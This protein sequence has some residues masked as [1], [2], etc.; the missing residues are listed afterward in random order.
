[1]VSAS[2]AYVIEIGG[3]LHDIG[4]IGVPDAILL[5]P[6]PLT[7][8]EW[9]LM[10]LHDRIGVGIIQSSFACPELTAI[11]ETHHS[12]FG[13]HPRDPDLPTG[14]EIP[15]GAR[16]LS[17]A[18][19]YD[20][21]VSD[22][23]YRKGRSQQKAFEELRRCAGVQFDP[24]LVEP[25]IE[26]VL[27]R[28]GNRGAPTPRVSKQAALNIGLQIESLAYSVDQEDDSG[29]ADFAAALRETAMENGVSGIAELAE[30]LEAAA[31]GDAE[32]I[33][34]VQLTNEL[35]ELCRAT[36]TA[37][38]SAEDTDELA[39]NGRRIEG[40]NRAAALVD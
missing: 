29:L 18:D 17:L 6:G 33:E 34:L 16:I 7:D 31:N 11:V 23:V 35:L 3:L 38:L 19:A 30:E 10:G 32:R 15:I 27:S 12:W 2:E 22:R 14:N 39:P 13:G 26:S 4:K 24:D 8:E 37:Y 1:M 21:M 28:D 40:K 5:K 9:K 36:Q 25:F 20:A